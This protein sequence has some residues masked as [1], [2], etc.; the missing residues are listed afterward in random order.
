MSFNLNIIDW[1]ISNLTMKFSFKNNFV[2]DANEDGN[3]LLAFN[4]KAFQSY[5]L[6]T[7]Y[8]ILWFNW[9]GLPL[10]YQIGFDF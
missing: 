9:Q 3:A 1:Q 10:F 5:K 7:N 4:L 8:L 2:N 6:I